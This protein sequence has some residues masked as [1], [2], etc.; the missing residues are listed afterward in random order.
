[1]IALSDVPAPCPS[2]VG[3]LSEPATPAL[4]S[5]TSVC[6]QA[7]SD[8]ASTSRTP[9][10]VSSPS[11]NQQQHSNCQTSKDNS[12][13]QLLVTQTESQLLSSE[14]DTTDRSKASD[15]F[16][17]HQQHDSSSFRLTS[18][19]DFN[20]RVG[21]A[22]SIRYV[23]RRSMPNVALSPLAHESKAPGRFSP[24]ISESQADH[25]PQTTLSIKLGRSLPMRHSSFSFS[26]TS[27]CPPRRTDSESLHLGRHVEQ[28]S[29]R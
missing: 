27:R 21:A 7:C 24:S 22:G 26:P 25:F 23:V 12:G 19:S 11:Y 10:R 3:I 13:F 8:E 18:H 2:K 4:Q 16:S 29:G 9:L 1:M 14:G 17:L 15:T 28:S 5:S 20:Q 6:G